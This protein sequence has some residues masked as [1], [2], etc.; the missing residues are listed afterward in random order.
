MLLSLGGTALSLAAPEGSAAVGLAILALGWAKARL[1]L[2]DYLGLA[3]A[4]T[5]RGGA[6][7][8]LTAL[9]LTFAAL[10]LAG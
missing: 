1:I 10:Y 2:R 7:A 6:M 8:V 5:W 4:P 3:A 9:C